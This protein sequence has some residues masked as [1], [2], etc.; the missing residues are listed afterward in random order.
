MIATMTEERLLTVP[1]VADRLRLS[2]FTVRE[3]LKEGRLR[4]FRLGGT[5]SGW[6]V[7]PEDLDA[8]IRESRERG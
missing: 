5:K 6:R 1:E 2:V 4:G 7:S 8:F 3:L